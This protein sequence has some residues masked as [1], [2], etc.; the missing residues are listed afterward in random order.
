LLEANH[1]WIQIRFQDFKSI[2]DY[3]LAIYK[4][5]AKLQFCEK[6]PSE[7][8]KI[9]KSLQTMLP[10]DRVLQHQYRTRNYQHYVDLIC[11]L[12]QAEK[13]DELTIKN[14]HQYCVRAAP[15][16]EI[17]H[18]EKK[19]SDYKDS[20]PKK[21]GRSAKRR[22]NK[23]KNRKLAKTMKRDGTSSKGNNVQCKI[24][25]AFKHT[26]EKCRTP[27][28]LVA[29]YQKSLGK[30][31]KVQGSGSGYEAH[32]SIPTNSNFEARCSTK[33]PQNSSTDEPTL[34]VDDYMD[35]NNTMVEYNLNDMFGD[36]H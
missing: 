17:H 29:L 36:L 28:H 13:H 5:C 21:N 35:S 1:E 34:T 23:Q 26:T 22:S 6:E 11:D 3:N 33:D 19:T 15:R 24:C 16:P 30:D 31:K 4:V 7:E 27:K 18:N 2:E 10:S 8:D 9:E 32:F 20:N 12:L 25:G 14:H